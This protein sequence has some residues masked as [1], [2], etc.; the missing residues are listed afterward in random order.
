MKKSAE[1]LAV[2]LILCLSRV[3]IPIPNVEPIGAAALLGGALLS[4]KWGL[5]LPLLALFLGDLVL[6]LALP[7][8]YSTYLFSASFV[9]VYLAF[10]VTAY[11]GRSYLKSNMSTGRVINAAA[12]SSVIFFLVTNFG[13]W[14]MPASLYPKSIGGL[15]A[16]YGAG[17]AF[18]NNELTGSFFLNGLVSTIFFSVLIFEGYKYFVVS[19]SLKT[20]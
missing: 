6:S 5:L 15:M 19:R 7:S 14:I 20:A 3:L 4:R 9:T 12:L 11:I 17:L 1:V 2:I 8:V 18:Y 10:M 13:S 16:C